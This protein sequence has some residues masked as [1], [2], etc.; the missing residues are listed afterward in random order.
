MLLTNFIELFL[1][2]A[3]WLL[4]GLVFAGVLKSFIPMAWMN[5]QLG[6]NKT[7]SIF[8]AALFGA[9]LPLCS[10]GV[11][12]AAIGLRRA[13]ASKSATT[14]FLVSTPE[15]GIDSI[16]L[17]YAMLG[18]FMAIIRPIA[19]VSSAI[20]AGL[21]VRKED[22]LDSPATEP[23]TQ[24]SCCSTKTTTEKKE[25]EKKE[26]EKKEKTSSSCC[27]SQAKE[28]VE[29]AKTSCCSTKQ[30]VEEKAQEKP[31]SSCC[32][33]TQTKEPAAEK[34]PKKADVTAATPSFMEKI[35]SG[36]SFATSNLVRDISIW[37][38]IG[39]FFAALIETYVP[40]SFLAQWGN[41]IIAMLVMVVISIPMYICASA[42][43]PIAAALL[44]S[45]VSPGAVLVF[46]LAGPATNIATL[47]V[48]YKELGK[49]SL[50]GYLSGVLI[51]AL[52]FGWLTDLLVNKFAINV[53]PLIGHDHQL[54]PE[55]ITISTGILLA[56]LMI[57]EGAKSIVK[58]KRA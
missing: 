2:S 11:I 42:S 28:T 14:S 57:K 3:P 51:G 20:L 58:W 44:L 26:P 22:M 37:L 41:G 9:P 16:S 15:T 29:V 54:L 33:S 12:P 13:G 39:L 52:F 17:S 1:D 53:T 19:A 43:T 32:S 27:S 40:S 48:V 21:L 47:G 45:G 49:R 8:K 30:P 18:P 46:M 23:K 50:I 24:S 55:F 34:A 6:N 7:S 25:L 4:I 38:I 36:L 31:N 56:I 10:C 5:K 35:K